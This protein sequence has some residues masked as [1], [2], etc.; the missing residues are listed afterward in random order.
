MLT[1]AA[2]VDASDVNWLISDGVTLSDESHN[3]VVISQD[4]IAARHNVYKG[5]SEILD[6]YGVSIQ[7]DI[8]DTSSTDVAKLAVQ[9]MQASAIYNMSLS[10]G[11]RIL[12]PTLSDYPGILSPTFAPPITATKGRLGFSRAFPKNSTSFSIRKPET[13]GIY[14]AIPGRCMRPVRS[15]EGFL[16]E[17]VCK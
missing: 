15:T 10:V 9:L 6:D 5:M 12:P 8:T 4:K 13:A 1:V 2:K 14:L 7:K 17:Y 11:A 16:D 3:N